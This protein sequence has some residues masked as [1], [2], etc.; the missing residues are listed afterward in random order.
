M[1]QTKPATFP[2]F[3]VELMKD[4]AAFRAFSE[5]TKSPQ[6]LRAF[7]EA[8]GYAMSEAESERVFE[9]AHALLNAAQGQQ[10]PEDALEDV[11][12]GLP[13]WAIGA[14]GGG[15]LGALA[16]G[17]ACVLAMV[18]G[19]LVPTVIAAVTA[20]SGSGAA[21]FAGGTAVAGAV[22]AVAGGVAGQLIHEA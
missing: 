12:G 21:A 9:R 22:S 1:T 13:A 8:N 11:N 7:A 5:G 4:E 20:L 3:L 15:T 18:G 17:G 14:I 10:I 2:E 19:P 16:F 6:D